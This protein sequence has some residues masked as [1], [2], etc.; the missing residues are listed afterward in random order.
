MNR[1]LES[2][3]TGNRL[4]R[5]LGFLSAILLMALMSLT[6]ADVLG[7][8][9]FDAPIPG[10]TEVTELMLASVVFIGLPA[11]SLER[12]HVIVDLITSKLRLA[13]RVVIERVVRV[14][15]AGI[16]I[17]VAW[18]IWA[19]GDQIAGY[20]GTTPTLKLPIA[21]L[22]YVMAVLCALAGIALF[23][24]LNVRGGGNG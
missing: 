15:S 1:L 14:F 9:L 8:Y 17:F 3:A 13:V 16:F 19:V 2:F 12:E 6:V 20:S 21:P 11:V 10:A 5:L 7:R 18:R 24:R 4:R 23:L 22:A